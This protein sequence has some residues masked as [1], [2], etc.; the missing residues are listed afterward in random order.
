[1]HQF[2]GHGACE[3]RRPVRYAAEAEVR[4]TAERDPT[5]R[6]P[7]VMLQEFRGQLESGCAGSG[8][9]TAP[10]GQ[11]HITRGRQSP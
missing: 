6:G 10:H 5:T 8:S 3:V 7:T 2:R 9:V 1:M 4:P 11:H